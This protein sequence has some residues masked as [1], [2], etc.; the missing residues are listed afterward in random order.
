MTRYLLI[1][2]AVILFTCA[3]HSIGWFVRRRRVLS[4]EEGDAKLNR[5]E[6]WSWIVTTSI[7]FLL[8]LLLV[9]QVWQTRY[10]SQTEIR[11][12]INNRAN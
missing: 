3:Q 8:L 1:L 7:V 5:R 12:T 11:N 6:S 4:D 2:L 10:A 9:E